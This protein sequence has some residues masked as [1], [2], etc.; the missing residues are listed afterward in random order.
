MYWLFVVTVA[1]A[2]AMT[3]S[4]QPLMGK[5]LLPV[6]GGTPAV[7]NTA[8]VF[9]QIM[10][11][12]GYL[13]AHLS[14]RWLGPRRQWLLHLVV[15]VTALVFLPVAVDAPGDNALVDHPSL[16]VLSTLLT[17]VG[18][19]FLAVTGTTPLIQRWLAATDDPRADDPY[20]LYAA[21]NCGSV[22][23]LIAYPFVL[24][25]WL[26]LRG[27]SQGWW[28][29]YLLL[30]VLLAAGARLMLRHSGRTIPDQGQ[31]ARRANVSPT[32]RLRWFLYAFVP[33]SLMLS[34]TSLITTDLAPMPLLWVLPLS[35]YLLSHVHAFARHRP[36]ATIWWIRLL[37]L[38]LVPVAC[39]VAL[40]IHE[41]LSGVVMAHL[42]TLAAFALAFHGL[43][44]DNRPEP[45]FLTE[46]Y[47]W[48]AIGGAA[49][50]L[51]NALLAPV[52][53]DHLLEYPLVLLVATASLAGSIWQDRL[54]RLALLAGIVVSVVMALTALAVILDP[55]GRQVLMWATGAVLGLGAI[56]LGLRRPRLARAVALTACGLALIGTGMGD[57][58]ELHA[59]RSFYGRHQVLAERDG[60]YHLLVHGNIA[61]GLQQQGRPGR[62]EALGYY[63]EAG[64][65]GDVF[66]TVRDRAP[67][68]DIAVVGLGSGSMAAHRGPYQRMLFF[69][70]DR[71]VERIAS[72]P[73][74]F[75]FLD[76]CGAGCEVHLGDGRLRLAAEPD[77]RFDLIVLDAY[78]AAA[79]P[80]HLLTREAFA[81][82]ADKLTDDG[83]L[84]FHVSSP[85]VELAPVVA[86]LAEDRGFLVRRRYHTIDPRTPDAR[87]IH[88]SEWIVLARQGSVPD[89]IGQSPDWEAVDPRTGRIWTDDYAPVWQAYAEPG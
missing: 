22:L 4:I 84:A 86:Q 20:H 8:M 72:D 33:S 64:P 29:L 82:F 7:W 58:D 16:W 52:L 45:A 13:Y 74:Y 30:L 69:E 77:D 50:G 44:A 51:F 15:V 49:G 14:I 66:E 60:R 25:P 48:M 38:L 42:I 88:D 37:P 78:S 61:H 57:A 76:R 53:F 75:D 27:Q 24:E 40:D 6:M 43:L 21:S 17:T 9:F 2:A 79:I 10:L 28:L 89:V 36:V 5:M 47:V 73:A 1:V 34:V 54:L 80:I 67:R 63:H 85:H 32:E 3:F 46:F 87:W 71:Q 19:P 31:P 41:P 55:A 68:G 83:L 62:P 12:A 59:A 39:A 65:L 81:M 35:L 26:G 70:I 11:L 18:L 23:A 56:A